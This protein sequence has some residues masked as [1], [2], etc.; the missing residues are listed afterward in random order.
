MGES[1]TV[2]PHKFTKT[3]T[4]VSSQSDYAKII[5]RNELQQDEKDRLHNDHREKRE[6]RLALTP[7]TFKLVCSLQMENQIWKRLN[8]LLI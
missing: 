8:E 4:Y 2:E 7:N 3:G 1:I 6:F 5:E